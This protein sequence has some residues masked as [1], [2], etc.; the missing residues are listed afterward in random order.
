VNAIEA[1]ASRR[2]DRMT[3]AD[4][5]FE[6]LVRRALEGWSANGEWYRDLVEA[7]SVVWL[8]VFENEAPDRESAAF[9]ARFQEALS[10]ALSKTAEP[11]TPPEAHQVTRLT[12]WLST[13]TVNNAIY[14][15]N[16][17]SGG[18][19]MRWASMQDGSVR[20]THRAANGQIA[21]EDG[22]FDIGGFNL[23]YPGEPVG[24]PEIWINCRCILVPARVEGA[25]TMAEPII[26]A[27]VDTEEPDALVGEV[28]AVEDDDEELPMDEPEDGEE[29]VTEIPVHGIATI[30][31]KPTGDG[32]NFELDSVS[33]G[34]LPQPM[35]F[36]FESSHGG[37]NSRVA[38]IGRIDEFWKHD[39]GEYVEV[40]WR[41]VV[42]PGKPHASE[43]I[44]GIIDGSYGGLS[45][46]ADTVTLNVE[47]TE[48]SF[49][50]TPEGGQPIQHISEARIRRHDM[51][52][53]PA[54]EEAWVALG[55]EFPDEM[56]EELTEEELDALAACG[57][58]EGY[59]IEAEGD[60]DDDEDDNPAIERGEDEEEQAVAA[61]AFAPGTK[62]GPGW[63]THPVA[64]SRIRRYWVRGKGA[65]KIRW[66]L[67]GDFNRCRRQ[68]A[69]YVQNPEWLAGLCANMH[70]EALG[71]WPGQHRG[72]HSTGGPTMTLTASA[73]LS[74]KPAEA[75]RIPEADRPT[76]LTIDG[77]RVYGHLAQ[78][79][80]CHIGIQDVCTIAPHS[81]TNYA[82]YRTG[83]VMTDEGRIPVGNITM[84]TG[85]A[86]LKA[87]MK[88]AV[89]HYDNTGSVV[90][91]IAVTDGKHGIWVSG[92]IRETATQA[93]LD[94]L[95]A[96]ALS[97]DWR[98]TAYG[99]E[100]VAALA[101]PV[102]GFPI[103]ALHASGDEG[104]VS[105]VAAGAVLPE[106]ALT[107]G[108]LP[109]ADEIAGIVRTAIEEYRFQEKRA[110]RFAPLREFADKAEERRRERVLTYFEEE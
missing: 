49:D 84:G 63:I 68:L 107:A 61:S 19:G 75:F 40:R 73:T 82:F 13:Y 76:P 55:A 94:A 92:L 48:Q 14:H 21:G 80:V 102:P 12:Y 34:V 109:S 86:G 8:E 93:Q 17:A 101:V 59:T 85:H 28:D 110:E 66:G 41:G 72:A 52:P 43:A 46:I 22:T 15:G 6:P 96:S 83:S 30:E 53:T 11:S 44:E 32:R 27:A 23:R 38:I 81:A 5:D 64:T 56:A 3:S 95:Q 42:F 90:A 9:L 33:W 74:V 4:D 25:L 7:V 47:A 24:P 60:P 67:P 2:R 103:V 16:R 36:E 62:D 78:W 97:G 45:I 89:A 71:I 57:C 20:D 108:L 37:D 98:R 31:G 87:S 35:G 77:D 105:L 29:L 10:E 50:E 39:N 18:T 70:K 106:S 79:G 51:V 100:M 104:Q 69:K 58:I 91:D 88:D 65:A 1:Y 26:A 54:Y 99:L